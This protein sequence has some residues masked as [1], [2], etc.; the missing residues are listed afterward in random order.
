LAGIFFGDTAPDAFY[1]NPFQPLPGTETSRK[2]YIGSELTLN[3]SW[4]VN[5]NLQLNTAYVHLF[6]GGVL[7]SV[8]ANDVN[9]F[10]LM[11]SYRF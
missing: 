8:G 11:G 4:Q 5:R 2:R 3:M 1:V 9:F 7:N 6:T 10:M